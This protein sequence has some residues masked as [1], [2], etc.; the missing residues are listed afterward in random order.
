MNNNWKIDQ[1]VPYKDD[2]EPRLVRFLRDLL[3]HKV[4]KIKSC[5]PLYMKYQIKK[6]DWGKIGAYIKKYKVSAFYKCN[7]NKEE[8]A[9]GDGR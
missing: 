6:E 9:G 4:S 8:Y 5:I 2:I 3:Y 1:A 7:F